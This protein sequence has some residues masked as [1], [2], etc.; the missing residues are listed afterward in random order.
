MKKNKFPRVRRLL[1][2]RIIMMVM[3][4]LQLGLFIYVLASGSMRSRIVE[5]ALIVFS[6]IAALYLLG[7]DD[8]TDYKLTWVMMILTVQFFGGLFYLLFRA[9]SRERKLRTLIAEKTEKAER[10]L[11][12]GGSGGAEEG[13]RAE[14][15]EYSTCAGYLRSAGYTPYRIGEGDVRYFSTGESMFGAMIED[16]ENAEKSIFIETFIIGQGEVWE[17]MF[18]IMRRKA[19][20]G[21]DVRLIYDDVGSFLRLPEDDIRKLRGCG[22]KVGCYHPFSP[23]WSMLQNNRDHRKLTIVDGRIAYTGGV[24][25]ADEYVNRVE[26]FG[27]WKDAGIRVVGRSVRSF[28]VMYLRMWET[29]SGEDADWEE[30]MGEAAEGSGGGYIIPYDDSPLDAEQVS[31]NLYLRLIHGA[32]EYLYIETPYLIPDDVMIRALSVA[33]RSGVDVR[34]MTPHIPDKKFVFM[35]TRSYYARLVREGVRI[36]EYTPGFNHSKV[37]VSDD[38]VANVGTA[39]MDYR[40]FYLHYECGALAVGGSV[41]SLIRADFLSALESCEEIGPDHPLCADSLKNRLIRPICRYFAP[42]L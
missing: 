32:R 40:S 30:S 26:R 38:A 34:I 3:L 2:R 28:I 24:N 33:A 35:T 42:L 1:R 14:Y 20:L 7:R 41:P 29:I 27:Y 5:T 12:A 15:G 36:Y 18:G 21:L 17:K 8:S 16:M 6:I 39:N 25:I 19:E 4:A 9:Q 23:F 10:Y 13:L 11:R 37:I 31:E 22:I